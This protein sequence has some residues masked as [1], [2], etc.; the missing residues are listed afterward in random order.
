METQN[1][2]HTRAEK[3]AQTRQS[4]LSAARTLLQKSAYEQLTVR[5]I[6][7]LADVS[8]GTFY[9]FFQSKDDLLSVFL[10]QGVMSRPDNSE[11]IGLL[12]Y[13]IECYMDVVGQYYDLGLEFTTHFFNAKNQAFNTYT[14]RPGGFAVDL[15]AS[16]LTVARANG[17]VTTALPID[18]VLQDIQSIVVGS[19]FEWCVVNGRF[20]LKADLARL[21]RGY[22]EGTVFTDAYFD[23][24]PRKN[25][26]A[27]SSTVFSS[28]E[29]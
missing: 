2:P 26:N 22:L 9:H 15:Y 7:Q 24:Y 5:N 12:E 25:S 13:I 4:I 28:T 8:T 16:K 23:K 20:D 3:S 11:A 18:T 27:V 21:L 17:F 6:C 29:S 19:M 10:H 1:L 14:R